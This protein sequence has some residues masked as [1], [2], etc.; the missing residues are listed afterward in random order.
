MIL[1]EKI[2][3]NI[4]D[5][6]WHERSHHAKVDHLV[7]EQWEAPKSRLRKTSEGGLELAI[8]LPRSEHL[9]NGDVLY[10]DDENNIIVTARIALKEV[11]VIELQGLEALEPL[12][13]LRTCF[14]LGHGLG[15]Q[16]W[17]AVIKGS[18]VYVP[19]SVDQKVMASVMRT[20]AFSHVSTRFAPGE[21]IAAL[22]DAKEARMLFAGADATPHHHHDHVHS[23]THSHDDNHSHDHEHEHDHHH[24]H[25]HDHHHG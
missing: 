16:H 12:E 8:S 6:V 21:E 4:K 25:S 20:H 11:L 10:Y 3:G 17:P 23:H 19:L 9:Q 13:I 1:V 2:L 18:T 22:L 7:L 15:N 5:T 24:S 14:E